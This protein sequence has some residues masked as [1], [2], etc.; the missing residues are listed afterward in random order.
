MTEASPFSG[1]KSRYDYDDANGRNY[2]AA[3]SSFFVQP[4]ETH[5]ASDV[6]SQVYIAPDLRLANTLCIA[7]T[8]CPAIGI[9]AV[10]AI[11]NRYLTINLDGS[12]MT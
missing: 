4:L 11:K 7:G 6:Y 12:V 2:F 8:T 9:L 10:G 3:P 1:V 5:L